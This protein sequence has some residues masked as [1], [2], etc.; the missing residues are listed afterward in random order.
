MRL[1]FRIKHQRAQIAFICVIFPLQFPSTSPPLVAR[2]SQ[3][4]LKQKGVSA[5][6]ATS[7]ISQV[8]LGPVA[9]SK[10]SDNQSSKVKQLVD[11]KE[12]QPG[13]HGETSSRRSP[14]CFTRLVLW[15]E[16]MKWSWPLSCW[17]EV[18]S[19]SRDPKQAE[20]GH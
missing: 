7:R 16:V 19:F 10:H 2:F 8:P 12:H 15:R 1:F 3:N 5:H 9:C 20:G 6:K 14:T 18:R 4:Q 11:L 13:S 17:P